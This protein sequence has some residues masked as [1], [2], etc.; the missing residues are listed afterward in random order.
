MILFVY[1]S[2]RKGQFNHIRY[3]IDMRRAVFLGLGKTKPA[4][5]LVDFGQYPGL[6]NGGTTAVVG[7]LYEI[8]DGHAMLRAIEEMEVGARYTAV[9][10][11]LQDGRKATAYV[12]L[13]PIESYYTKRVPGG[14]W[15]AHHVPTEGE[16]R[17]IA[18][19][20]KWMVDFAHEE[21]LEFVKRSKP[22]R[23]KC[24]SN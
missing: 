11:E 21:A 15:S 1:G 2:L 7:E 14:D 16:V 9:E 12:Q 18:S 3:S 22:K 24:K 8:P 5:T 10:L 23:S 6:Y 13:G 19:Q 17:H 4:F 20:E